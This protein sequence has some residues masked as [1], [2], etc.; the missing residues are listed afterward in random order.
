[1]HWTFD[2][3]LFLS[4]ANSLSTL[5]IIVTKKGR[6][7]VKYI[8]FRYKVQIKGLSAAKSVRLNDVKSGLC[9]GSWTMHR[10]IIGIYLK[11]Y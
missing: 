2:G 7:L 8:L 5:Y 3:Y 10:N 4:S 11:G 6:Q 1:M 9:V